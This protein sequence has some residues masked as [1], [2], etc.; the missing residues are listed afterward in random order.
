VAEIRS[1]VVHETADPELIVAEH[2]VVASVPAGGSDFAIPGLL[3]LHIRD[4]LITRVRDYM[5]GLA[6]ARIGERVR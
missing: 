1:I 4:G 5:D 2:V 3:L 6:V